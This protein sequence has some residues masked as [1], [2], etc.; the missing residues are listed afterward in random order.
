M[1]DQADNYDYSKLAPAS[2]SSSSEQN[3]FL[4]GDPAAAVD[5]E[6]LGRDD[7]DIE[8]REPL[9]YL[10]SGHSTQIDTLS[11]RAGNPTTRSS[12]AKVARVL[13]S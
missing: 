2:P 13:T 1:G 4:S 3:E 5:L 10:V 9:K 8:Q 6:L 7:L 11:D 12:K